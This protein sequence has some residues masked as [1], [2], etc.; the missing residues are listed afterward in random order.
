M[1]FSDRETY[2]IKN[3]MN[4]NLHRLLIKYRCSAGYYKGWQKIFKSVGSLL[5]M[6]DKINEKNFLPLPDPWP[7]EKVFGRKR[8]IYENYLITRLRFANK[9]K[10]N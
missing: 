2:W 6:E 9:L 8:K 1:H 7:L 3:G 5:C 10:R 4:N